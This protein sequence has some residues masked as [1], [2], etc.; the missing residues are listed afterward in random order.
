MLRGRRRPSGRWAPTPFENE[1]LALKIGLVNSR[2]HRPQTNG[3]LERFYRS[4]EE[5]IPRRDGPDDYKYY[6]ADRLYF[7]LD[8]DNYETPLIAFRNKKATDQIRRQNTR[9]MEVDVDD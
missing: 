2:P 1:L 6:N 4:L 5:K 8:I 3:K 9:W 7:S